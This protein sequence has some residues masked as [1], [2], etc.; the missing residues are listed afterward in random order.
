MTAALEE[1]PDGLSM[2]QLLRQVNLTQPT[3]DLPSLESPAPVVRQGKRW[4]DPQTPA[5]MRGIVWREPSLIPDPAG[6]VQQNLVGPETVAG[7]KQRA[8]PESAV[9]AA[10]ETPGFGQALPS[11][12]GMGRA[13]AVRKA[14]RLLPVMTGDL[15]RKEICH[16]LGLGAWQ[17]VKETHVDP[18]LDEGWI[19]MTNPKTPS[20]PKQR[21]RRSRAGRILAATFDDA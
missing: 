11:F 3:I 20:S 15:S 8:V 1:A 6:P 14:K 12:Q 16:A 9:T 7:V 4:P 5:D 2:A 19:V 10:R 18:C 13:K 21:L 17:H